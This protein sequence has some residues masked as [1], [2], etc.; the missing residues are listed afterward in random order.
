MSLQAFT[1]AVILLTLFGVFLPARKN[2]MYV[3]PAAVIFG[4]PT[5]LLVWFGGTVA[6]WIPDPAWRTAA[7]GGLVILH[8]CMLASVLLHFMYR[9]PLSRWELL[10]A[11]PGQVLFVAMLA[12]VPTYAV[13][14]MAGALDLAPWGIVGAPFMLAA[15]AMAT[16]HTTRVVE[17]KV[18]LTGLA[19]PLRIVHLSD[20]HVGTF[21]GD[22]RLGRMA[23]QINALKP[24]LV[25][26]TGDFVTVRSEKDYSPLLRFFQS[27]ERPPLGVYG[28]LGNHDLPVAKRLIDDLEPS[29]VRMLVNEGET[30]DTGAGALRIAGLSFFW[31]DRRKRYRAAFEKAAAGPAPVLLLCHDPAAFDCLPEDWNGVMFAGH[32]HGGQIGLTSLG[33]RWSVLKPLG[34]YDQGVFTRGN[35]AMYV[36][37]GTGVYGFPVR[38]G[39]PAEVAVLR[40][41]PAEVAV[42]AVTPD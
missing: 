18:S 12:F 41:E 36:H 13:G 31:R 24:D 35:A 11:V 4:I 9:L 14:S 22:W 29:G 10:Y 33:V 1:A 28:C 16:T 32:L 6:G 19:A 26:A 8:A 34:M 27:L 38:L 25:I 37:R 23:A 7:L 5:L 39:V 21:M 40:V 42:S 30:I 3:I 2:R 20:M 15:Y 17:E